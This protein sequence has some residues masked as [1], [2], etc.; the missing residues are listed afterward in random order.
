MFFSPKRRAELPALESD[1][2]EEDIAKEDNLNCAIL[3]DSFLISPSKSDREEASSNNSLLDHFKKMGLKSSPDEK[4]H[5]LRQLQLQVP[6]DNAE[7]EDG[8][9]LLAS[10]T[11]QNTTIDGQFA[12]PQIRSFSVRRRPR[13]LC[14]TQSKKTKSAIV[15]EFRSQKVLFQTPMA[16]SRAP[17]MQNDSISLTL[18]DTINEG[19]TPS[20]AE[21]TPQCTNESNP[22][23]AA[24]SK[25]SL[26]VAFSGVSKENEDK[27]IENNEVATN[28]TTKDKTTTVHI[29][30]GTFVI[31]KKLGCG[32]SSSVYLAKKQDSDKEYALKVS[33]FYP[34][35]HFIKREY[36]SSSY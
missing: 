6:T 24:R 36:S 33:Y 27:E 12:T 29:N 25:K 19:G 35:L 3:N 30:N 8:T 23:D 20:T 14:S 26:E 4:L 32:G 21:K 18:C 22:K 7:I 1:S 9:N 34:S 5:P 11:K 17:I 31:I 16:I 10:N 13:D 28:S 2:D 15:N